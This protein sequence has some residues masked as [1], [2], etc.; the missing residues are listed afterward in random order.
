M[1]RRS[2]GLPGN[3]KLPDGRP[4]CCW[5]G[6]PLGPGR[7]RWCG[8]KCV[9]EY[10][11]QAS[12]GGARRACEHRDHGVCALCGL[13]CVR[14]ERFRDALYR[15]SRLRVEIEI[16]G[17]VPEWWDWGRPLIELVPHPARERRAAQYDALC[18]LIFSWAGDLRDRRTLWEADHTIPLIEGGSLSLDNL[19]TLCLRCHRQAT[20]QL[21]ARRALS[22]RRQIALPL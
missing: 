19:R 17:P 16:Q 6:G 20:R 10:S 5:C 8:Q 14:V 15:A 1:A 18:E 22:R 4:A 13:D 21:A 2:I 3:R 11:I 9:D 7:R 12:Q